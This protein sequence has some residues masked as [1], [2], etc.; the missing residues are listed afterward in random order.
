MNRETSRNRTLT[1]GILALEFA[2]TAPMAFA[3]HG[4]TG[5]SWTEPEQEYFCHYNLRNLDISNTVTDSVCDIIGDAADDW[6][7]MAT[8]NGS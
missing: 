2:I 1:A 6:N 5:K 4:N 3:T 7:D 8:A